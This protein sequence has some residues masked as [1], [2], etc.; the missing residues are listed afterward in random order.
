M[1]DLKQH[2]LV[3]IGGGLAGC[4]AAW[5]AATRGL[6]VL[7]Y[8]M[9]PVRQTPA[10][11]TAW[12][13]ELVCSN[14][15]KSA[16][17]DTAPGLLKEELR[18]L[19]SLVL[20]MA[21][22]ARIP[23][24]SALAVDREQFA[25]SISEVIA[26]HASITLMREE[27]RELPSD[28]PTIIATG[29]L[30]SEALAEQI[31]QWSGERD[32]Y[33]HDAISPIVDAQTIDYDRVFF[34]SRHG[35]GDAGDYLNCP[36]TREEYLRFHEALTHATVVPF[37]AFEEPRYFEA[38]LP[39][40]EIASRGL[41]TLA[42]G[43][44]RPVGLVDGQGRRDFHAVAQLRRED[45]MGSAF[46]L[47]GFQTKMTYP[48]QK[49]VFR[50]IPGLERAEF[51][52]FGSLHRNTYINSPKLLRDTLQF[53]NRD[54]LFFA[55]Q[56]TG[57]EGY[58]ESVATGLLA[59]LNVVRL[60]HR[61]DLIVPPPSTALGALVRYIAYATSQP[62]QPMNINFG[63]LPELPQR[64][65]SKGERRRQMVQRALIA[66]DQWRAELGAFLEG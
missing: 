4:E 41:E 9:R 46:N 12:L 48:E 50:L 38:C 39:I 34:A 26:S 11:Q 24:G 35:E 37:H 6:R 64:V 33:F 22:A 3:I 36:F 61:A 28:L 14:S 15:L 30:T 54:D 43:P 7:L 44:M 60:I 25:R 10:H 2:D 8:E 53:R 47:V 21:D 63:L 56:I 32:L 65:R 20:R 31:R 49:R 17:L 19:G 62:F 13:A 59:G 55:G 42:Y 5:Q 40:E 29:P 51:L 58:T 45:Q 23:A 18:R 66:A 57:V 52:R 1:P 16:A 27:V